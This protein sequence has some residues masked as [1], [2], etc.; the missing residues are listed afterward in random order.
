MAVFKYI[1][2]LTVLIAVVKAQRP[3]YAGL[4]PIGVPAV[5]TDLL[6]NRFGEDEDLPIEARGD[7]NLINRI[8]ELPVDSRPF[9]YLN[10]R[11]YEDLR[12]NPVNWPQRP[13]PFIGSK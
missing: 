3:F 8:N 10:W 1:L 12:R 6:S 4:R 7:A 11:Q 5:E 9:W 13:N 2:A